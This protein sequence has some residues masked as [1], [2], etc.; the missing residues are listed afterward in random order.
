MT[1]AD[2]H[3]VGDPAVSH[4]VLI[5]TATYRHPSYRGRNLPGVSANVAKLGSMLRQDVPWGLAPVRCLAVMNP[6][7]ADEILTAIESAGTQCRGTLFVY[8]AGHGFCSSTNPDEL[9][10]THSGSAE[11]RQATALEYRHLRDALIHCGAPNKILVL[12]CCYAGNATRTMG[13]LNGHLAIEGTF[14]LAATGPNRAARADSATG[15]TAFT[16]ELV[17]VLGKDGVPGAGPFVSIEE[18]AARTHERLE[19]SGLPLPTRQAHGYAGR[20]PIFKNYAHPATIAGL[21]DSLT[22]PESPPAARDP[23]LTLPHLAW[24]LLWSLAIGVACATITR[25]GHSEVWALRAG[26]VTS[27]LACAAFFATGAWLTRTGRQPTATGS[28]TIS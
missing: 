9:Y 27:L 4:A 19:A 17:G 20:R 6:T 2:R 8:Y 14:V 18:V 23:R 21:L 3:P 24:G 5:G 22:E 25:S 15:L 1:N 12:D 10:L 28:R 11:D 16:N 7:S 13:S 26:I